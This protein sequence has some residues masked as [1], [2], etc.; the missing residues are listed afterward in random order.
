VV[1]GG[2]LSVSR[3]A[4]LAGAY[5]LQ[6]IVNDN[7]GIY[8]TDETPTG[9]P[10]Y[11]ARFYFDPNS[12]VMA[13]NNAHYILVG[14][15]ISGTSPTEVLRLELR[16][17]ASNYQLRGQVLDDSGAFL[18]SNAFTLSDAPH[19][20]ELDWRAASAA[21]ANNGGLTLWLDGVQQSNLTGVDN[22]TRN[23]DRVRFG[24]VAGIDTNTRGTY[25]FDAF[26]AR[27]QSY[28]GPEPG[29]PTPTPTLT[30]TVTSLPTA[31][32]TPTP[33]AT[34]TPSA[35]PT[36]A[37]L[38]FKDGFE[39][40]TFSAWSASVVD[41]GDLSVSADA[42][43][44]G[45]YG[46]R[47]QL[48]DNVSIFVTDERPAS[49]RRYRARVYFDPNSISMASGDTHVLFYGYAVGGNALAVL[50]LELRYVTPNYQVRAGLL[51]NSRAWSDTAWVTL[52]DATHSL[53][54]DWRAAS[55]AGAN[56]G[57]L[58]LWLDGVQQSNLTGVDND[59]RRIDR[60]ELGA[61]TGIDANT[62]GTY[63]F[64]AFEAR[65]QSYIGP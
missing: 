47:A 48:D 21:G 14:D 31:T 46:L 1:D 57:G 55:A 28:I 29:G 39:T 7:N 59:T 42:A 16:F 62:R 9:E 18:T 65:R 10:R 2:D 40:G 33:S 19:V 44:V 24:A 43:L 23:V 49:E 50:R 51:N 64:D 60:V 30:P 41:G 11:R 8:L 22:D 12:I 26:E 13:N 61:V 52:S 32:R 35:T 27:R 25:F 20:L 6:A 38:I 36:S 37:D 17:S 56:D 63:F 15:A 54:W 58:T 4:A 5:G 34:A 53:E 45:G 3:A